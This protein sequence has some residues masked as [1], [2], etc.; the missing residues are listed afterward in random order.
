MRIYEVFA[1]L[2]IPTFI[3]AGRQ[4]NNILILHWPKRSLSCLNCHSFSPQMPTSSDWLPFDKNTTV[5][6]QAPIIEPNPRNN[7]RHSGSPSVSRK[8]H[9]A[10]A[11][12]HRQ[13]RRPHCPR[14]HCPRCPLA[15]TRPP[16]QRSGQNHRPAAARGVGD[17]SQYQ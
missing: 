11:T 2:E 7:P 15:R 17:P 1:A 8:I 10:G 12:S 5:L 6:R 3:C 13:P 9:L 16:E 14:T 4:L